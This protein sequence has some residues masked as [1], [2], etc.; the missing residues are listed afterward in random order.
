M[1]AEHSGSHRFSIHE[2]AL[3]ERL[4]M[5]E[6]AQKLSRLSPNSPI[7]TRGAQMLVPSRINS[8]IYYLHRSLSS[9][10]Q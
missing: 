3:P 5:N 4:P 7:L 8:N 6:K 9:I 10:L 2:T 1:L